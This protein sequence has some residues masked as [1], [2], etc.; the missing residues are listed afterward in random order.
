MR[1]N[2]LKPPIIPFSDSFFLPHDACARATHHPRGME[3]RRTIRVRTP[4]LTSGL[5]SGLTLPAGGTLSLSVTILR[6]R[7]AFCATGD[8][9]LRLRQERGGWSR[10]GGSSFAF[11]GGVAAS[12]IDIGEPAAALVHARRTHKHA[13]A[14]TRLCVKQRGPRICLGGSLAFERARAHPDAPPK[15]FSNS[16]SGSWS[17]SAS[18]S[19]TSIAV[20]SRSASS[21]VSS[22][23]LETCFAPTVADWA[24]AAADLRGVC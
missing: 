18:A 22:A 8:S 7:A 2:S 15:M 13:R 9:S 19:S 4:G 12:S 20:F 6:R 24:S 11:L 3:A 5:T 21:A 1:A 14:H 23:V 10:G 16:S 17:P